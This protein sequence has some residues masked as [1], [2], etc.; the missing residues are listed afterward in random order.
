MMKM[1]SQIASMIAM[2]LMCGF[3]YLGAQQPRL[4]EGHFF[5]SLQQ[6]GIPAAAVEQHFGEWF[7]V[8][9]ETEWRELSRTTDQLGMTRI[10]Y[11]QYVGGVEVAHA[12]VIVHV[13][14]GKVT[15]ADA[16]LILRAAVGLEQLQF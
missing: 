2:L 8:P 14:D 13:K 11:K 7:D 12:Q 9:A 16:R 15:T 3:Q 6:K 1:K 4:S 10:E 5:L